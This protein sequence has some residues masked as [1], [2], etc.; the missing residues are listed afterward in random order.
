MYTMRES[1]DIFNPSQQPVVPRTETHCT[2]CRDC[3]I[4]M[5][6]LNPYLWHS[7]IYVMI[8]INVG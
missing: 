7:C 6:A 1:W 8:L 3:I 4:T 2:K 5:K